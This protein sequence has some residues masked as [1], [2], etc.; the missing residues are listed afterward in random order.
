[1]KACKQYVIPVLVC[2]LT[3]FV[4]CSTTKNTKFSRLYQSTVTKY[5]TYFNGHEAYKKGYIAQEKSVKDNYIDL[6]LLLPVSDEQARSKGKEDFDLA[7][8]KAQKCVKLHSISAKPKNKKGGSLSEKEK[9]FRDKNEYNPFLWNAWM[10]MADAQ[11]QKGEFIEAAGTYSYICNLYFDE[12]KIIA[13]ARIKTMLC[14]SEMGW[15]YETEELL[16]RIQADTVPPRLL[17]EYNSI[18]ASHL[19]RQERFKESLP[20]MEKGMKRPELSKT[21]KIREKYLLGQLYKVTGQNEKAYKTFQEVIRMNPPYRIEFN[22]RIQQTETMPETNHSKLFKKL[23]RMGKDPNNKEYLDQ[24][25]YAIGNIYLSEKDTVNALKNY[26]IGV[27]KG[28]RNGAEK[29]ILLLTMANLYWEKTDYANAGICYSKAVGLIDQK[30]EQYE[31]VKRRSQVL[32]DLAIHNDNIL[33]QDSLQRL[34]TLDRQTLDTIIGSIIENV[35]QNEKKA[36]LLEIEKNNDENATSETSSSKGDN[37]AWY[38][39]NTQLVQN[40]KSAFVEHWG[41]RKFEDDWRRINKTTLS[42]A[43]NSTEK[44]ETTD[45]IGDM[46]TDNDSTQVELVTDIHKKE[47]YIQQ[48]PFTN[49]QKNA[50]DKI[51][52]DALFNAGIIYKDLLEEYESAENSFNRIVKHYPEADE[53]VDALY[54]LYLMY[55]LWGK[56]DLADTCKTQMSRL[57]PENEHTLA[58]CDSNFIENAKYGKHREDSLYAETYDA[59]KSGNTDLVIKN[60]HISAEKYPLGYHRAKFLFLQASCLLQEGNTAEFLNLLRLIVEKYPQNEI[61]QLAGL[62]AQGVQDGKILQSKSFSSIWEQRNIAGQ[63]ENIPDSVK[64]S[65][66]ED[67]YQPYLFILAYPKDSIN[68]NRLLFE[69]AKYNFTNFMVR[70][71]DIGFSEHQGIGMMTISEFMN[72]DEA[73]FYQQKLFGDNE[74]AEKIQGLKAIIITKE[75]LEILLQFYSF[76]DYQ[77]F[78]E[79]HFLTIPDIDGSTIFEETDD[80]E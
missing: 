66:T 78:Y 42:M 3:L 44:P 11:M 55:S 46:L 79:K 61:S 18:I 80:Y 63:V 13:E 27:E 62:I 68:E 49:E 20:Y 9:R 37:S 59:Y 40:G 30:N 43:N 2:L 60:C 17:S 10:L 65:F 15:N 50:S 5:N 29:G 23:G 39:Y 32:E 22:A 31:I 71:F 53:A 38:F 58:I 47:Y 74:M 48:I 41:R 57:Y 56:K 70:N 1:M 34:A 73:Y 64:P 8:E 4:S 72:Y 16:S 14:Y 52:T 7:I 75:N 54:N 67:R 28:T 12:P 26:E 6:L 33:L 51:L 36:A 69:I 76:Q 24:I 35:I 77:E 19:I 45:S 25:Y 21:S